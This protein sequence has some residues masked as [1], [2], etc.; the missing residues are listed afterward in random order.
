MIW[1]NKRSGKGLQAHP[2]CQVL[3][4]YG[5]IRLDCAMVRVADP[6]AFVVIIDA[7]EALGLGF[8]SRL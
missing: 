3:I 4:D 1:M 6:S 2:S 7:N 8:K 5:M